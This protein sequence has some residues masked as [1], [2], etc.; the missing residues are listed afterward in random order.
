MLENQEGRECE[1]S[2]KETYFKVLNPGRVGPFSNWVWP[3][4]GEWC[5]P[6]KGKLLPC[7]GKKAYHGC[8]LSQLA[9][10]LTPT[11][12]LYTLE[13]A[14]KVFEHQGDKVYARKA[15]LLKRIPFSKKDWIE[16]GVETDSRLCG[17]SIDELKMYWTEQSASR[18]AWAWASRSA[19]ESI[20][21]NLY[22][23]LLKKRLHI[24]TL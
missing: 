18:L 10:W 15:R 12:E 4:E 17:L 21:G 20:W 1:R 24:E 8:T 2:Q 14:P 23:E 19:C 7:F 11:S 5:P 16:L 6:I 9:H 13:L 3:T 22:G